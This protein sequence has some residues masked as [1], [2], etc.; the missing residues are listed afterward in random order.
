MPDVTS[1]PISSVTLNDGMLEDAS[2]MPDIWS[3]CDRDC[4]TSRT[5]SRTKT[6]IVK[7]KKAIP[8]ANVKFLYSDL[9]ILSS[10]K[11]VHILVRENDTFNVALTTLFPIS[12][13]ASQLDNMHVRIAKLSSLAHKQ[14]GTPSST[15]LEGLYKNWGINGAR[16]KRNRL[17]VSSAVDNFYQ[18]RSMSI[19]DQ[20]LSHDAYLKYTFDERTPEETPI[21]KVMLIYLESENSDKV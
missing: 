16:Y 13:Y 5:G 2:Q 15:S 3:C 4:M 12:K 14:P 10:T 1:K 19:P 18:S 7:I 11:I 21:H 6:A 9:T 8:E 17:T 20:C